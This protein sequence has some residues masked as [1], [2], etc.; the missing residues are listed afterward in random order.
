MTRLDKLLAEALGTF[1]LCFIGAGAICMTTKLGAGGPGL[2]GVAVAHG[3]ILSIA[4]SATMNVSGGH[5][6]PA[7]TTAMLVTG[8]IRL[9][10]AIAYVGSQLAGGLAAGLLVLVV[11]R[12]MTTADGGSVVAAAGLGTPA[13]D[14][15]AMG[16]G[17]AILIEALLTFL[18]VFAI[19]GT[20]VDPRAPKI[21]G[22]GIGLA[23]AADI[24]FGGPLTGAAMNPARTFGPGLVAAMSGS[25]PVFWSQQA[26]Y[27]I[28]PILGAVAG[29]LIYDGVIMP[30]P[31]G[32]RR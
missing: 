12:G 23:V 22:F 25:L 27:W 20:A 10:E 31:A 7:V 8:R 3:L 6:N 26:V 11:F 1:A 19:F 4:V 30:R 17:L 32:E 21:G 16:M 13:Y 29:A 9:P 24:L 5:L 15:N 18:L 2:L 14:A 28:G